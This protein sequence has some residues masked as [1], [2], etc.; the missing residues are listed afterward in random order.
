MTKTSILNKKEKILKETTDNRTYKIVLKQLI[1]DYCYICQKRCGSWYA[2]C[3][4]AK[5]YGLHGNYK[6]IYSR[7]W[8]A[9]KTWKHQRKQQYKL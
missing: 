1:Y 9:Y 8:R 5:I 2:S 6:H 4:P 3:H 7:Q